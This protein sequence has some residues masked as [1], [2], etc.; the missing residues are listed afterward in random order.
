MGGASAVDYLI[1]DPNS[2]HNSISTFFISIKQ[3]DSYHYP[4]FFKINNNVGLRLPTLYNQGQVLHPNLKKAN[5]YVLNIK[6]GLTYVQGETQTLLHVVSSMVTLDTTCNS[7]QL[8]ALKTDFFWE[9]INDTL[10]LL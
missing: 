6:H 4:L 9:Y 2:P 7:T 1:Y 5:Q 10:K 3:P 8:N